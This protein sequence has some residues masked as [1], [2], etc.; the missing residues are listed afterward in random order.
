MGLIPGVVILF[1]SLDEDDFA[2]G[3]DGVYDFFGFGFGCM[4]YFPG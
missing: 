3:R 2:V 1:E 4:K